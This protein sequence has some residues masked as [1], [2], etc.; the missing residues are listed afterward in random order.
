MNLKKQT[1]RFAHLPKALSLIAV[2]FVF[3]A[4]AAIEVSTAAAQAQSS[5][6]KRL[7]RQ[8]ASSGNGKV[9]KRYAKAIRSQ[10]RQIKKVQRS[11][12]SYGCASKKRLFK[13]EAHAS[14]GNLR[15]TLGKM[16]SNLSSLKRDGGSKSLSRGEKRRI[17]RSMKRNGCGQYASLSREKKRRSIIEQIFGKS[18][19]QRKQEQADK[20]WQELK[21]DRDKASK[22][23]SADSVLRN[24]NTVRTVCVRTCDGYHFPVS[25]ST[26]KSGIE[27]DAA[28][29]A[30]LCPG[31]ET[32]LYIH[33]TNSDAS[34]NMTSVLTGQSYSE[35]PNAFAYQKSYNAGC[36]CNYRLLKRE[37]ASVEVSPE[38]Q[39]KLNALAQRRMI[40]R[41]ALPAWR[42]DRG[43][44]PETISNRKGLLTMDTLKKLKQPESDTK[45]ASRS[46]KIRVIGEEF[47]PTQ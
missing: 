13:R 9:S 44:D 16:R 11:L 22:F 31:T 40:S 5:T 45:V 4:S 46:S 30:N 1:Q 26:R 32:E 27:R 10:Q 12:S 25:F 36:S 43:Q 23:Q 35:M 8:L 21:R 34:E 2:A 33:K 47:L 18:R 24:Y 15:S 29:C 41:I 28:A 17:K 39:A 19:K 14:C 3:V 42:S 20:D 7:E 37:K 6:C 38:E